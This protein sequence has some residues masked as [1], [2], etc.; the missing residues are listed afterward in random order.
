MYFALRY[1]ERARAV[2]K[3]FP[4]PFDY[5]DAFSRL[6]LR[7]LCALVASSDPNGPLGIALVSLMRRRWPNFLDEKW[8]PETKESAVHR[9]RIDPP[10]VWSSWRSIVSGP[11]REC[12]P[13]DALRALAYGASRETLVGEGLRLVEFMLPGMASDEMYMPIAT[14]EALAEAWHA[15]TAVHPA[16]HEFMAKT[17]NCFLCHDVPFNWNSLLREPHLMLSIHRDVLRRPCVLRIAL[18]IL[19]SLLADFPF[20][21]AHS[22]DADAVRS[23]QFARSCSARIMPPIIDPEALL[24]LVETIL[25]RCLLE[26]CVDDSSRTVLDLVRAWIYSRG[27]RA[28]KLLQTILLQGLSTEG[29]DAVIHLG[30]DGIITDMLPSM[31]A[32]RDVNVQLQALSSV[33]ALVAREIPINREMHGAATKALHMVQHVV[34]QNTHSLWSSLIMASAREGVPSDGK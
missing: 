18:T 23:K 27:P 10:A 34:E 14:A 11:G 15:I 6:P 17:A 3:P 12:R 31:F 24:A 9:E 20:E 16:P 5:S 22:I 1:T 29:T 19:T 25:V 21:M 8:P 30:F 32:H 4:P 13:G 33:S 2:L 26:L 7:R 28:E